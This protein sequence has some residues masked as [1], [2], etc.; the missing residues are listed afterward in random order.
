MTS[1]YFQLFTRQAMAG[2]TKSHPT[3]VGDP[4]CFQACWLCE[5]TG[6]NTSLVGK[7][8]GF[9]KEDGHSWASKEMGP[10]MALGRHSCSLGS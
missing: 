3:R 8:Q 6:K 1:N 2:M 5:A 10:W 4:G 7:G 9:P